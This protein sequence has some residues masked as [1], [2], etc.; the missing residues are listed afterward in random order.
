MAVLDLKNKQKPILPNKLS[1]PII[2]NT[3]KPPE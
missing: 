1:A 2:A 3:V